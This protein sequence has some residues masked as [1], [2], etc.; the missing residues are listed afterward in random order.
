MMNVNEL[1]ETFEKIYS[2]EDPWRYKNSISDR[3]R[4]AIML[5]HI[6]VVFSDGSRKTVLD[7]GC[8]EGYTTRDV[9]S[10]YNAEIDAFDISENALAIARKRN[11]HASINY[12][13]LDFKDFIP[14][15]E[16]D[17]VVCEEALY[18]LRDD[19]ERMC[20]VKKFHD[21]IKPGSFLRLTSI[22][23]GP[24]RAERFFTQNTLK[25]IVV[26]NGFQL[27]SI[28]P[29]TIRKSLPEKVFYRS[30]EYANKLQP[31]NSNL[32]EYFVKLTLNR[33]LDKC[34]AISILAKKI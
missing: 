26:S 16:Y 5:R 22:I 15:K 30:L 8:G 6:E 13:Q 27:V 17:L 33:P 3:T 24:T 12:F 32:I 11:A 23:V 19:N 14:K 25:E 31:V 20:V 4:R 34:R 7:A 21:S 1:K 29:S 10:R 28:W 18:Y 9:A 2:K